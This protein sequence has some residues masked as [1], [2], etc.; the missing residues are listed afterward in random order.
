MLASVTSVVYQDMLSTLDTAT[1]AGWSATGT[2]MDTQVKLHG[3]E[4]RHIRSECHFAGGDE[5]LGDMS[6]TLSLD[7]TK[8]TAVPMASC[9]IRSIWPIAQVDFVLQL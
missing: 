1:Q 8:L 4:I 3:M 5:L 7:P 9:P 2:V 6:E